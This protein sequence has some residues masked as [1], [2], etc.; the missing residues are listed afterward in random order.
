[1]NKLIKSHIKFK[2]YPSSLNQSIYILLHNDV[3]G[4]LKTVFLIFSDGSQ[5]SCTTTGARLKLEGRKLFFPSASLQPHSSNG[6][7]TSG[8]ISP[9]L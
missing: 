8:A 9:S 1:M 6:P 7:S 3:T 5:F 4:I 2:L